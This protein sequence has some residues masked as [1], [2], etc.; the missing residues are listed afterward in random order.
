M[1]TAQE[2]MWTR[3]GI[4]Q[5]TQKIA[6]SGKQLASNG[7]RVIGDGIND[8]KA[9]PKIQ[10]GATA[11]TSTVASS[12]RKVGDRLN[13]MKANPKIQEGA[14]AVSST[15]SSSVRL[16]GE[17]F[18]D[19]K[20]N[21]KVREGA[22]TVW[23]A[24]QE[25]KASEGV[26]K[27]NQ[28]VT[29]LGTR[30]QRINADKRTEE[31]KL[32]HSMERMNR[33][34][35]MEEDALIMM[36]E[37]EEACLRAITDHFIE[38]VA[39]SPD[40]VTYEQWIAD[41]HPENTHEGRLLEGMDKEV[42]HRFYVEDSDHRKLWNAHLGGGRTPVPA[43]SMRTHSSGELSPIDLLDLNYANFDKLELPRASSPK[44][45]TYSDDMIFLEEE[46]EAIAMMREAE[47]R[48]IRTME[49]HFVQF[50][51]DRP[52]ATYEQWIAD[53][54][55]ENTRKGQLFRGTVDH[56][57]Y[58]EGSD[59]RQLWN[60]HLGC[61]RKHV[62]ARTTEVVDEFFGGTTTSKSWSV[63][64]NVKPWSKRVEGD[65][66]MSFDCYSDDISI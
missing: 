57:F 1:S 16:V 55:P 39:D 15:V 43:R 41:L 48:C 42:D 47:D 58:L 53:L 26:K 14:S 31:E 50:A 49:D 12:V 34:M 4:I 24:V 35:Q 38:F 45:A 23:D 44:K 19:I 6:L 27:V 63:T 25:L 59:H 30:L 51:A 37:S 9:N 36:R 33:D 17:R 40:V 10:G 62:P 13:D 52:N 61:G 65:D 60:A 20:T 56:R 28:G 7:V 22:T 21:P 11:V 29:R 66:L 54:H 46:K 18:N 8:L 64:K 3:D 5:R 32:A 2:R